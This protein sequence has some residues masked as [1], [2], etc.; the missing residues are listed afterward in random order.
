[1]VVRLGWDY[2]MFM[3]LFIVVCIICPLAW[4][5]CFSCLCVSMRFRLRGGRCAKGFTDDDRPMIPAL[6]FCCVCWMHLHMFAYVCYIKRPLGLLPVYC[7]I[8]C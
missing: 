1:M 4:G 5:S 7:Y 8:M 3:L 6:R 2:Y